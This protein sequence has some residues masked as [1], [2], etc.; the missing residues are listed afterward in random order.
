MKRV[1]KVN[2]PVFLIHSDADEMMN[3]QH[4]KLLYENLKPEAQWEPWW[5]NGERHANLP[6]DARQFF[7]RLEDFLDNIE[8]LQRAREETALPLEPETLD[9]PE[10]VLLKRFNLELYMNQYLLLNKM[11]SNEPQ[12]KAR[13]KKK[14]ALLDQACG[15]A[16]QIYQSKRSEGGEVSPTSVLVELNELWDNT[17][18][19]LTKIDAHEQDPNS[20]QQVLHRV[21]TQLLLNLPGG[22]KQPRIPPPAQPTTV[23]TEAQRSSGDAVGV[24]ITHL[25]EEAGED[26]SEQAA[27]TADPEQAPSEAT[28]S[29]SARVESAG[30]VEVET[31]AV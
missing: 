8:N 7:R 29:E 11:I 6:R 16:S 20:P 2:V 22:A 28:A 1:E 14:V 4:A 24:E 18:A 13:A 21:D 31:S 5:L 26:E 23:H 15:K 19:E 30:H 17:Q 12:M 9:E 25:S 27:T 10:A 3:I